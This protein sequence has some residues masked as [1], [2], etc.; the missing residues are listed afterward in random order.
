MEETAI[1]LAE[2]VLAAMGGTGGA[3]GAPS[4]RDQRRISAALRH[5]EEHAEEP[6]GLA[7]LAAAAAMS[8]YHFLRSFR[9]IVGVT[10]YELLLATRMR[11]A[12]VRLRTTTLPVSTIAFDAGFGDLSTF[13]RRFRTLFG[14]SPR[15]W[16]ARGAA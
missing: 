13:N 16:R 5:I 2:S 3:A 6:L 9:R 4:P 15:A 7:E 1:R 12:A 11:R 10:P 8:K 14:A